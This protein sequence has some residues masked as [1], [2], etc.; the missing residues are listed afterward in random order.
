[1]REDG[2]F[3][4][5][6]EAPMLTTASI[7]VYRHHYTG[8]GR[9][10]PD[11]YMRPLTAGSLSGLPPAYISAAYFDPLRDDAADYARRLQAERSGH[12]G[13]AQGGSGD[14]ASLVHQV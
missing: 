2:S 9:I 3:S 5:M 14:A 13:E 1:M 8:G 10:T 12:W 7:L 6:A 4:E 11:P